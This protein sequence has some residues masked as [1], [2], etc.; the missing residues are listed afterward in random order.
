MDAPADD[1]DDVVRI[2]LVGPARAGKSS[3]VRA[4]SPTAS[5][6]GSGVVAELRVKVGQDIARERKSD[7]VSVCGL[8]HTY[9]D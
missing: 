7:R 6:S 9:A 3:L 4:L 5:A 2:A 8:T 1:D